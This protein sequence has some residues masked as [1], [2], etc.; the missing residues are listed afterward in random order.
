MRPSSS[1]GEC[2]VR[3]AGDEP[4]RQQQL[5]PADHPDRDEKEPSGKVPAEEER[6]RRAATASRDQQRP[7]Y[8]A[9]PVDREEQPE[10]PCLQAEVTDDIDRKRWHEGGGGH[11]DNA[12][13]GDR[14]AEGRASDDE[15]DPLA[16]VDEDVACR[17]VGGR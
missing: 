14:G 16:D 7:R 4:E 1:S 15:L 9:T 8:G 3:D 10:G 11:A 17:P 6:S 13:E 2:A 5:E 12:P